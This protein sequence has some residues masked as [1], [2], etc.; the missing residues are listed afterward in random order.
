MLS[1]TKTLGGIA[2]PRATAPPP[3]RSTDAV[4]APT[5]LG[6]IDKNATLVKSPRYD[7][8]ARIIR[9]TIRQFRE[10]GIAMRFRHR[11]PPLPSELFPD[12][13][14]PSEPFQPDLPK[15]S[16]L[17]PCHRDNMPSSTSSIAAMVHRRVG[18]PA[19]FGNSLVPPTQRQNE[20]Q[21]NPRI[22]HASSVGRAVL[23]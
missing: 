10:R 1:E 14:F 9:P 6:T 12:L 19:L 18:R 16:E 23:S 8:Q 22:C 7:P 4:I 21:R 20:R 5:N 15:A 3:T 17:P 11:S 2:S 13:M